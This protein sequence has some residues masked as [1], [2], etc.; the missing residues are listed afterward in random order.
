[1]RLIPGAI[2]NLRWNEILPEQLDEFA[3]ELT[4]WLQQ[5]FRA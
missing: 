1:M 2:A 4:G 3:Q 5:L